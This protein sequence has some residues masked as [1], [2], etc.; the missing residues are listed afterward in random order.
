MYTL[1]P[2]NNIR[3]QFPALKRE[4]GQ[5]PAIFLDGPAG[6]QVPQTVADAVSHYMLHTNANGG[7]F[8]STSR[9]S[10]ALMDVCQ[11]VAAT[12]FGANDPGEIVFG[13]N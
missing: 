7:G 6:S 9:E 13:P 2:E 4:H 8:F 1:P 3:E 11:E 12:F 10:D 5:N